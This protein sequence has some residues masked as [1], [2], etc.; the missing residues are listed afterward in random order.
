VSRCTLGRDI[1]TD[2][3][4]ARYKTV[5]N[6]LFTIIASLGWYESSACISGAL[7]WPPESS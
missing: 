3:N 4:A 6:F 5:A 7:P 1:A 2:K